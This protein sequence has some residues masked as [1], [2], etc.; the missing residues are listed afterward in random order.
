ML[1]ADRRAM[2]QDKVF[3]LQMGTAP[4]V[5]RAFEV[6][7]ALQRLTVVRNREEAIGLPGL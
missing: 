2:E 4:I 1:V 6:S 5:R 3:R 7:G